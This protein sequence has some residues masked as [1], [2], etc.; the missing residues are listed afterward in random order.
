MVAV[1]AVSLGFHRMAFA[2]LTALHRSRPAALVY[3]TQIS[4]FVL[5]LWLVAYADPARQHM[6][7][8]AYA[9][10]AA[11]LLAGITGLLLTMMLERL[12]LRRLLGALAPAGLG[13]LVMSGAILGAQWLSRRLSLGQTGLRLLGEVL[14]GVVVYGSYLRLCHPSLF[15]DVRRFIARRN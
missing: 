2:Q 5:G 12:A 6:E 3:A 11:L 15:D 8:T 7:R 10:S 1:G 4:T 9:V 14:L 13:T